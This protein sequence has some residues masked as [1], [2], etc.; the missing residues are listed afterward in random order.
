MT[1]KFDGWPWKKI[2]G[3]LFYATL[4]FVHHFKAIGKFN[5]RLQS[6]NVK[7]GSKSAIFCLVWPWNLMVDLEKNVR[8]RPIWVKIDDFFSRHGVNLKFNGWSWKQYGTSS[9]QHQALCIISSSHVNSNWS[10][11]PETVKL[12]F[13]LCDLDLWPWPF[14]WTPLWSLEISPENFMMIRWREYS[15]K[16]VTDGQ[17]DR[18][19]HS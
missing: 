6:G 10:C 19:Y 9:K 18:K 8:K 3:R 16:G 17:T 14:A 13:D 7:F 11:S 15:Q 2:I 12:G 5:V 4:S 1:L